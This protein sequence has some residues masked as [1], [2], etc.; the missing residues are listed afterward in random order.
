MSQLTC[1][2]A[3]RFDDLPILNTALDLVGVPQS[4]SME[5]NPTAIKSLAPEVVVLDIDDLN[6][7]PFETLRRLRFVL[8]DCMMIVYTNVLSSEWCRGCRLAGVSGIRSERSDV[9]AVE[10]GIRPTIQNGCF[11][12][13]RI[14]L[15]L[16]GARS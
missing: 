8:P 7:D 13:P 9:G 10:F 16:Y 2:V 14:D 11:T 4:V 3:L 12:D 6:I 1:L 5:L 15:A